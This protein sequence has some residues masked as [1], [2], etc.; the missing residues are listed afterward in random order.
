MLTLKS[1]ASAAVLSGF[2]AVSAAQTPATNPMPDG[3]RDMYVGLGLQYA[4]NYEGGSGHRSWLKPALQIEWSNGMFIAGQS[5]GIHLSDRPG[6]EYGPLLTLHTG[7][8]ARGGPVLPTNL[9]GQPGDAV[10]VRPVEATSSSASAATGTASYNNDLPRIRTRLEGGAF[11][12]YY[13]MRELRLAQS[14]SYGAGNEGRGLRWSVD[15]QRMAFE[16][17]PHHTLSVTAGMTL[18]NGSYNREFFGLTPRDTPLAP[19]YTPRGGLKDVHAHLRWTWTW[20]PSWM[21]TSVFS[22]QQ[23]RGDARASPIVTQTTGASVATAL[24]YRF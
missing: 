23:L 14:L 3:S 16:I 15:L 4:P 17:A 2:C 20:S 6:V 1:H 13:L 11:F 7:R 5:A 10:I 21:L 19:H 22:V 9:T 18:V 24:A 8:G 12:N